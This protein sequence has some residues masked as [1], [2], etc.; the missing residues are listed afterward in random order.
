M[1]EHFSFSKEQIEK[2]LKSAFRDC[3]I[4]ASSLVPEVSFRF[5][6]DAAVF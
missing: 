1:F 6:Y 3:N 2:Y 5:C 4:A